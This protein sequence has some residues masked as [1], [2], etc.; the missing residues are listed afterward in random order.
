ME[1]VL[2]RICTC[3]RSTFCLTL[4]MTL[5][6]LTGCKTPSIHPSICLSVCRTD[7]VPPP[8]ER[9]A[10]RRQTAV[11][12]GIAVRGASPGQ[13]LFLGGQRG[14][15]AGAAERSACRGC[16]LLAADRSAGGQRRHLALP[17]SA[18]PRPAAGHTRHGC[19]GSL[20][21]YTSCLYIMSVVYTVDTSL[22]LCLPPR[23][24]LQAIHAM[25]VQVVCPCLY[26]M[27]IHH[28]YTR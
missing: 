3:G 16:A 15:R 22:F 5:H 8:M 19:T 18:A 23:V 1:C 12:P 24:L 17:L 13:G 26:T 14:R 9:A 11:H 21:V 10:G 7:V 2:I 6:W 20:S 25:A 27:S 28:V 4:M